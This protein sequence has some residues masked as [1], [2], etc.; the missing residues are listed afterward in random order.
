VPRRLKPHA[1]PRGA[2]L[3]IAAPA[4]AID[5]ARLAAGEARLREAGYRVHR[6][7][8]LVQ[9]QT[10]LAGSDVRRARELMALAA[11][12][13]VDAILCTRG[14]YGCQRILDRLD[15]AKLRAARK[16]VVGFSDVTVLHLWLRRYAGLT[17]IHGPMFDAPEGPTREELE[18]LGA[19]LAGEAVP[20]LAGEGRV[21][22]R[23]AGVLVGGSLTLL[24]ASLGTPWEVDTRGAILL[25][26]EIGEKPYAL[27]RHLQHLAQAGKLDAAVGFGVGHLVGCSDPKRERPTAEEVFVAALAPLRRP[28]V[29]G[30]PFGHRSPNLAWPVGVRGWIDGRRGEVGLLEAGVTGR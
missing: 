23:A 10:F 26:E 9:D 6:R 12:R 30:L 1:A 7:A 28:L 27:D 5:A 19:M 21:R 14:G 25:F 2:T 24:C 11:S 15:A 3:G 17:S 16:A 22:G 8:D 18:R 13:E 4:F 20:P 29:L